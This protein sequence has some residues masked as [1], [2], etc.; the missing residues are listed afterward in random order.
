MEVFSSLSPQVVGWLVFAI[1][2]LILE[3]LTFGLVSIWF[4]IGGLS[5]AAVALAT[6]RFLIQLLVF[7]G[8]SLVLLIVTRPLAWR[9][10]N[11]KAVA[12]NVDAMTGQEAIITK[13]VTSLEYGTAKVGGMEWTVALAPGSDELQVGEIGIVEAVEGVK[14]IVRKEQ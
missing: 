7:V 8:V 4:G 2:M 12:T 9:F 13:A 14:L 3:G 10:I 11:R 1:I 5:A 6:D